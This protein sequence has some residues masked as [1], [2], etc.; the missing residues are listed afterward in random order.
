MAG[1][2]LNE[3]VFRNFSGGLNTRDAAS[4]LDDVEFPFSVNVTLDE[5]GGIRKR[6]GFAERYP[7]HGTGLVKNLFHWATRDYIVSQVGA[8]MHINGGAVFHTWTTDDRCGMTEFLGNLVMIHPVDGT[9]VYDGTSVTTPT[10]NVKGNT[11]ATWQNK[12]WFAG[13]PTNPPRLYY[14]DIGSVDRTNVNQFNDLRE[15]DSALITCLAG[16]A[17]QDISGRPGLLVFKAESSYR[18]HDSSNGAYTTIDPA[19][20]CGSNIGAVSAHGRTFVGSTRGIYSTDGLSPMKEQSELIENVFHEAQINQNRPDLISA[21][22]YGDRLR[23]SYPKAGQTFNSFAF[24]LGVHQGWIVNHT[25]AAS[26]YASIGRTQTALVMGSPTVDGMVYNA[27][28]GGSDNGTAITSKFQTRWLEPA[29][30]YKARIRRARFT[31]RGTFNATLLE[32]YERAQSGVTMPVS[33]VGAAAI[34]DDPGSIYDTDD[35]YGPTIFQGK[36][37][38][39]SLGVARAVSILIEETSSDIYPGREILEGATLPEEGAWALA[40]I[41]LMTIDLGIT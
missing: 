24:E 4:E 9:R 25:D 5:R 20:G 3:V 30:G 2:K 36:Q 11:V 16:A 37:D 35:L 34:Y 8:G 7:A 14:S 23:F 12:V 17:G 21:G 15:K 41:S 33:I 32:D 38:F 22:R 27:Y 40:F 1:P 19:I 26:C 10:N 31:G 29:K 13:D 39:Y 6:L 28:S 18:V